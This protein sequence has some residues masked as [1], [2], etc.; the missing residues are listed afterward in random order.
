VPSADLSVPS[1]PSVHPSETPAASAERAK[2]Y[3]RTGGHD[4]GSTSQAARRATPTWCPASV[5][6]AHDEG[7][8]RDGCCTWCGY[9]FTGS[10]PRPRL[11]SGY[12]TELDREYR[13]TY[14]LDYGTDYWD[15]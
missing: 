6:G 12:R 5:I 14:D 15:T 7:S 11:G 1:A 2:P 9:R 13:R 8:R 4:S 3:A 10:A